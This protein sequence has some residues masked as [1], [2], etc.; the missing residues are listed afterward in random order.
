M[1]LRLRLE[2][3]NCEEGKE[4]RVAAENGHCD[5]SGMFIGRLGS[6]A[7]KIKQQEEKQLQTKHLVSVTEPPL[8]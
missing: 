3:E 8:T 1:L 5:R 6:S 7:D 4:I 2:N